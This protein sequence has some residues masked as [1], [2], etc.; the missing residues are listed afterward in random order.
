MAVSGYGA[1]LVPF[2]SLFR[3]TFAHIRGVAQSAVKRILLVTAEI[4]SGERRRTKSRELGP[5]LA[6]LSVP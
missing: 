4:M 6:L 3:A 1:T 5:T 2:R